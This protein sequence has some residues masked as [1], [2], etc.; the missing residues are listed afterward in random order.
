MRAL[1]IALLLAT[2]CGG[3][4]QVGATNSPT[5]ATV[6][7]AARWV[8]GKP[9]YVFAARTMRDAQR[10]FRDI[11]DTFGMAI[12]ADNASIGATLTQILAVDPMSP[13][14]V[15]GIGVDLDGG[16]AVFSEAL[17]PTFVVHLSSPPALHA[18]LDQQRQRGLAA[19]SVM[20]DGT[21]VFSAAVDSN[22][23][24][25]WAIDHDWLWIHFSIGS[26]DD[27]TTWFSHS[28]RPTDASWVPAWEAAQKLG[29][30][31]RP[32]SAPSTSVRSRASSPPSSRRRCSARSDSRRC[33]VPALSSKARASSSAA[34]SRSIS[35]V[36]RRA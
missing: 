30:G 3:K 33:A 24:I 12:G 1:V 10:A 14:A 15:S 29:D 25:S 8:P 35:A 16:M 36:R 26:I 6:F 31:R 5:V 19:Q 11:V 21:E 7:P 22:L 18:F 2:G 32:W 34:S 27:G 28:K 13:D 4:R 20:V 17:N 9:T 23:K